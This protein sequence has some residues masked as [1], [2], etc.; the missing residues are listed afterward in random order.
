MV[1]LATCSRNVIPAQGRGLGMRFLWGLFQPFYNLWFCFQDGVSSGHSEAGAGM[2]LIQ[3]CIYTEILWWQW[4][5]SEL[6]KY[7]LKR[8]ENSWNT[9]WP[10]PSNLQTIKSL[11]HFLL[12]ILLRRLIANLSE[13]LATLTVKKELFT[14]ILASK[15]NHTKKKRKIMYITVIPFQVKLS[16]VLR[17][18]RFQCDHSCQ[19]MNKFSFD[20]TS[21]FPYITKRSYCC[22]CRTNAEL[23]LALIKT[24]SGCQ[25]SDEWHD[26]SIPSL[27]YVIFCWHT[28]H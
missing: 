2:I 22:K 7:A 1:A 19:I 6:L 17:Q 4:W 16:F 15:P 11:F 23:I 21:H 26:F 27:L 5:A 13:W 9:V 18:T 24:Q 3:F 14:W 28:M 8:S 20:K 12:N 25:N 10:E